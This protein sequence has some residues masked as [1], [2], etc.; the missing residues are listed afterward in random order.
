MSQQL[1]TYDDRQV[2]AIVDVQLVQHAMD[3]MRALVKNQLQEGVHFAKR[4]DSNKPSLEKPGAEVVLKGFQCRPE[5][6]V[7][8]R[9]MD[10]A[11]SYA[12]YEVK[13]RAIHVP[14]GLVYAEGIGSCD[15]SRDAGGS[16]QTFAWKANAALKMAEKSAMIATALTLGC[17]SEF[18]TQDMGDDDSEVA[19]ADYD[20]LERCPEHGLEWQKGQYGP[21]HRVKGGGYCNRDKMLAAVFKNVATEKGMDGRKTAAWLKDN[22]FQAWSKLSD[23]DRAKAIEVL[24]GSG[25]EKQ[26]PFGGESPPFVDAEGNPVDT[27]QYVIP[28]AAEQDSDPDDIADEIEAAANS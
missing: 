27:T 26:V 1:T 7:I 8:Y 13:C 25:E 3:A 21:Y 15:T 16:K 12:Y 18:F 10:P 11:A 20:I 19:F 9:T 14:T 28:E 4:G 6:E 22:E 5:F 23:E 24:K 2:N 17:V